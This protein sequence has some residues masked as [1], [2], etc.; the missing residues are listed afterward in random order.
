MF[1][2]IFNYIS[3]DITGITLYNKSMIFLNSTLKSTI[4]S[5]NKSNL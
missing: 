5:N 2:N 4:A 3:K 1:D